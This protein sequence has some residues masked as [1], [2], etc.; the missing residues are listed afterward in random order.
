[1]HSL[2][3]P[4]GTKNKH[5]VDIKQRERYKKF[6]LPDDMDD[7]INSP[8]SQHWKNSLPDLQQKLRQ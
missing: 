8:L 2:L 3:V 1:M 7:E 6:L 5:H 4:K